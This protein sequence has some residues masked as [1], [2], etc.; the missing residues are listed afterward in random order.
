MP[1]QLL[2]KTLLIYLNP[3]PCYFI[4]ANCECFRNMLDSRMDLSKLCGSNQDLILTSHGY[5]AKASPKTS[6]KSFQKSPWL[7]EELPQL[8]PVLSVNDRSCLPLAK[9]KYYPG[10]IKGHATRPPSAHEGIWDAEM[11]CSA[12]QHNREKLPC[13]GDTDHSLTLWCGLW[14]KDGCFEKK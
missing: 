3:D 1:C 5:G 2:P 12:V 10:G 14:N 4:L 7:M 6:L 11:P 8:T 9:G 13:P